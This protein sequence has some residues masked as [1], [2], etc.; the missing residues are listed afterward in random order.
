MLKLYIGNKNYS[1]WSMR[2]WVLMQHA[3]IAFEEQM[4]RFESFAPQSRFKQQAL[5]LAPTGQVPILEDGNLRIWDSLAIAEYLAERHPELALWPRA[6]ADRALARSVCAD[7]HS[8]FTTLRQLLP[9]NIEAKLPEIGAQLL[10]EHAAL[11]ADVARLQ[12]LWSTLLGR[13]Q[14]PLLFDQFSIADAYFAPMVTRLSTYAIPVQPDVAHYIENVQQLPAV[15]R[16]CE[17]AR[18]EH[19]FFAFAEP[20]RTTPGHR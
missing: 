2:P 17:Q 6:A 12:T 10:Q 18:S 3:G 20:Y 5:Q 13:H 19:D 15:Q 11:A 16:W 4:L 7:M 8:G 1:S 14:G 9:M